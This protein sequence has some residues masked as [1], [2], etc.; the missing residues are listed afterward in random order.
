[1]KLFTLSTKNLKDFTL[2]RQGDLDSH[3]KKAE[4]ETEQKV[5]KK[6]RFKAQQKLK[7]LKKR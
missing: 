3:R 2:M 5:Q 7:N 4:K 6:V 1:M